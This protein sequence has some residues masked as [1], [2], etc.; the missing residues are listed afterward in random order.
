MDQESDLKKPSLRETH[1]SLILNLAVL[2]L[3]I[4]MQIPHFPE[5]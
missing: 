3:R 4:Q 2:P 5:K 1:P